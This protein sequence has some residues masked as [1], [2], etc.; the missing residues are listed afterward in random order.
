MALPAKPFTQ[1]DALR[2]D[3]ILLAADARGITRKRLAEAAGLRGGA[4]EAMVSR[5]SKGK[6]H[7]APE[8]LDLMEAFLESGGEAGGAGAPDA[9]E[10][11]ERTIGELRALAGEAADPDERDELRTLAKRHRRTAIGGVLR[12]ALTGKSEGVRLRAWEVLLE[13]S[14]GKAVQEIRDSTPKA[15]ADADELVAAVLRAVEG[16]G[17]SATA[18]PEAQP[19][20]AP[21]PPEVIQ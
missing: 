13:R 3:K 8:R 14:D 15:P 20:A 9:P 16:A 21:G 1:A 2:R 11:V 6:A 10:L 12:I 19:D 17:G 5:W 4:G 7:I 18:T